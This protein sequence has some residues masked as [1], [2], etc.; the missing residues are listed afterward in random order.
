MAGEKR[1]YWLTAAG[2]DDTNRVI[3]ELDAAEHAAVTKAARALTAASQHS[4]Q[5]QL[6]VAPC[7]DARCVCGPHGCGVDPDCVPGCR[8]PQAAATPGEGLF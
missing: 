6:T 3:I 8:T 4:C 1:P 5:P 2:C 7:R